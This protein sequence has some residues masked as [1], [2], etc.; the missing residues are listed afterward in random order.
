VDSKILEEKIQR[1]NFSLI[2]STLIEAK[3]FKV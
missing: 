2:L 1:E 3:V